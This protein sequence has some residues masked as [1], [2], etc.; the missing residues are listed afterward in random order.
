MSGLFYKPYPG[1]HTIKTGSDLLMILSN[2]YDPDKLQRF[3]GDIS[4]WDVSNIS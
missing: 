3:K 1:A 2:K 4:N